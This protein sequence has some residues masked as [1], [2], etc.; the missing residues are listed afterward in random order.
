MDTRRV[1]AWASASCAIAVSTGLWHLHALAAV[2][3]MTEHQ[4]VSS[5]CEL[6]RLAFYISM[7]VQTSS[8]SHA[9]RWQRRQ[10]PP[11]VPAH[12]AELT[13]L[14]PG[15]HYISLLAS[16]CYRLPEIW[17]RISLTNT[18]GL[19]SL[20]GSIPIQFSTPKFHSKSHVCAFS[21]DLCFSNFLYQ[22]MR[23]RHSIK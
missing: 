7:P 15:N 2:G 11:P 1:I 17:N 23:A 14:P 8:N 18:F 4:L 6:R 5:F 12:S 10:S 16:C 3:S 13:P 22:N 21:F 19:R 9:N 20:F